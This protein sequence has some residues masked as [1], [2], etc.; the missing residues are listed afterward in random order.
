M[1][2]RPVA[3][4]LDALDFAA[5]WPV[6]GQSSLAPVQSEADWQSTRKKAAGS[7]LEGGD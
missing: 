7:R 4:E 2:G 6:S 5:I 3:H 1:E